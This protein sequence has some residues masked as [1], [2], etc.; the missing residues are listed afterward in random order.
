MNL[1]VAS[2]AVDSKCRLDAVEMVRHVIDKQASRVH[3][4]V[5]EGG[6]LSYPI[7]DYQ[8]AV[9]EYEGAVAS[10]RAGLDP[11]HRFLD[12]A[13]A[14]LRDA[15]V[16]LVN[17]ALE[18]MAEATAMAENLKSAVELLA[19]RHNLELKA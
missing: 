3:D 13:E 4:V 1:R 7:Q 11:D 17:A 5:H 19:S 10:V 15:A 2:L 16:T 8:D 14:K 9:Y 18:G 12:Q 6:D